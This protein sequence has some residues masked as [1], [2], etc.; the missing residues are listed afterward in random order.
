MMTTDSTS[1]TRVSLRE[2]EE[3][4]DDVHKSVRE[5]LPYLVPNLV[6][7]ELDGEDILVSHKAAVSD[8]E[9]SDIVTGLYDR[10][11]S[12]FR[13][14]DPVVFH[15]F[16]SAAPLTN[17]D[18]FLWLVE[19]GQI[20]PTGNGKFVYTGAFNQLFSALDEKLR[21]LADSM[22]AV[23]ERYPTT[24][25]TDTL[26]NAGYLASFPHHAFFSAPVQ[27]SEDS[28]NNVKQRK[29]LN[30]N[31]RAEIVGD[32][33]MPSEVLAPTVCYHCFEARRNRTVGKGVITAINKCH[34]HE[35]AD[36]NGL[37]R[38][39]TY[40]M[41]EIIVFGQGNDVRDALDH[42]S[43]WTIDF[44]Q[45]LDVS[46]D[47]VAANDPFFADSSAEKRIYQTAYDL[48]R[49][50]KLPVYGGK[51]IAAASFNHHQSSILD[52]LDISSGDDGSIESGCAGWGI[53]RVLL[54]L[55]SRFGPDIAQWPS[56][57]RQT[58]GL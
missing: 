27:F 49:E 19:D 4:Y 6:S 40:W 56:H 35:P 5:S 12:S 34:R 46:V 50:L 14:D 33:G 28:L 13:S 21:E 51:R 43:Q 38:L 41:R 29:V 30:P 44:L 48:K 2:I 17:A 25:R 16:K 52:K 45:S 10:I 39:T 53:E 20:T 23:E 37:E 47:M 3:L 18:P 57:T 9:I 58:L 8:Q 15:S 26:I 24:V 54:A 31:D 7:A 1:V 42:M 55:V 32:L 11:A 22:G 36:V